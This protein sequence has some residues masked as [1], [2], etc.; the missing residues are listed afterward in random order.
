MLSFAALYGAGMKDSDIIRTMLKSANKYYAERLNV[1]LRHIER[2]EKIGDTLA[3]SRFEFPDPELI[4]DMKI[5]QKLP[6]LPEVLQ[7]V[8]RAWTEDNIRNI[9]AATGLIAGVLGAL[10]FVIVALMTQSNFEFVNLVEK[11]SRK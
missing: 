2:G 11:F 7:K 1:F 4:E 3:L 6:D 8:A 9:A 5:Y 10:A